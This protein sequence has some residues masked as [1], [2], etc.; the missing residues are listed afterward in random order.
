MIIKQQFKL[1]TAESPTS[2]YVARCILTV[3]DGKK[4]ISFDGVR[5]SISMTEFAPS[6]K[7]EFSYDDSISA[8]DEENI[9]T[10]E[11]ERVANE[12]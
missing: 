12:I 8:T 5:R 4:L 11:L 2:S 10:Y 9:K 7:I 1:I 3:L 6:F